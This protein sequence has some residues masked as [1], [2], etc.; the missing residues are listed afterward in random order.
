MILVYGHPASQLLRLW[1]LFEV[2]AIMLNAYQ[3]SRSR[4]LMRELE[5]GKGLR[6][7]L[8]IPEEVELWLDSGG[9][10]AM[11]RGIAL[12]PDTVIKWYN[13]MKADYCIALDSPVKP[14][15][16]KAE[17]KV[18]KNVE[19]AKYMSDKVSCSL[20][21]VYHPV[22][23]ELLEEYKAGY[24]EIG[25]R[26]AV[27]GLIPRILTTKNASRK[28]G[29]NFLKR[30]REIDGR[31]LH[32]LGLGSAT[33]IPVLKRMNYQSADTQT[34][35]HK[36]AYGKIMLPGKG[37]RHITDREVRFGRKKISEEEVEEALRIAERLGMSWEE[38]RSNFKKRAIF[39]A[40]VLHVVSGE[41]P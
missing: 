39:N 30:V 26:A 22:P 17:R 8:G 1:E 38:L 19:V 3:L 12:D 20:L 41:T 32:A 9:Y 24:S 11:K 27:G 36:A 18:K 16:P 2:K 5:R 13:L 15:D 21:P 25:E 28:E 14:N 33:L 29:W 40:Y 37:E 34:W 23:E 7:A 35:R 6:E 4:K 31:W 10:Q